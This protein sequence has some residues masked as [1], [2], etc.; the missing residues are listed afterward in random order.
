MCTWGDARVY[1]KVPTGPVLCPHEPMVPYTP[2]QQVCN[3]PSRG[4]GLVNILPKPQV[5]T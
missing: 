5:A 4:W 1:C 3:C 2:S